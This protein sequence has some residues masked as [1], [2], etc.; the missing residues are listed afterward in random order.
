MANKWKCGNCGYELEADTPPEVCPSC[1]KKCEFIDN[2][3][4]T[5]ECGLPEE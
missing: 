4:Y 3:C 2:N 1:N 5:P